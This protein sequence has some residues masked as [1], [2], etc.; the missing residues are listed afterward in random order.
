MRMRRSVPSYTGYKKYKSKGL[1]TWQKMTSLLRVLVPATAENAPC[2]PAKSKTVNRKRYE[3]E[4]GS[5]AAGP[6]GF[7]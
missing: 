7:R 5:Q 3:N 4:F 6:F 1:A 2:K